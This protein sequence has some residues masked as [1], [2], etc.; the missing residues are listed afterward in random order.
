MATNGNRRR[1][2]RPKKAAFNIRLSRELSSPVGDTLNRLF[3]RYLENPDRT[4]DDNSGEGLRLYSEMLRK[5]AQLAMCFRQRALNVM[6]Q[7]WRIIPGGETREDHERAA[8]VEEVLNGVENLHLSRKRF[9]RGISHG[10]APAEIMFKRRSDSTLGIACF[11]TR[12]PERFRF[13]ERGNLVLLGKRP[14]SG[15]SDA[16]RKIRDQYLGFR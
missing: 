16:A 7:G 5:D 10:Y 12:D 13:D 4:L 15:E 8:W 6:A 9:F 11:R 2:K 1:R 14:R 3:G